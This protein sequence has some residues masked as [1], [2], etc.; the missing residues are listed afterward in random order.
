MLKKI[1][2]LDEGGLVEDD[3]EEA[4]VRLRRKRFVP[5]RDRAVNSLATALDSNNYNPVPAPL[6]REAVW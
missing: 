1:I 4:P 5:R 3:P 2:Y 6:R